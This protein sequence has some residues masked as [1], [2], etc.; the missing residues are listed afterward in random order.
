MPSVGRIAIPTSPPS[1]PAVQAAMASR[2]LN[3]R[4]SLPVADACC[5]EHAVVVLADV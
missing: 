5:G 2:T 1:L 4:T 3:V